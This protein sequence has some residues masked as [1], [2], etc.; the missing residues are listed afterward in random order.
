MSMAF[1]P[2]DPI[3]I[4]QAT[5]IIR[6]GGVVAFPSETSYG[7]AASI[8]H[9][10]AL[11]Q[12]YA[13]KR[14]A[15]NKPLLVLISDPS[16]L[17]LL[18]SQIPS[19]APSLIRRFWP[20]PLTLLFPARPGLP[21]PLCGDTKK[22]G[23]RISSHPWAQALVRALGDPM[24]ATSANLSGHPPGC[25]AREVLD[26]L[27]SPGPDYIL[28]GGLTSGGAPSTI[29]DISISPPHIVRKGAIDPTLCK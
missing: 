12:I 20:G 8:R 7:L 18:V 6:G 14:R 21:W 5:E 1:S 22:V 27:R 17:D 28:D 26:Q 3:L 19:I 24:T 2:P 16:Q 4:E 9:I 25:T 10:H 13:I 15:R 23:I 29:L 11:E